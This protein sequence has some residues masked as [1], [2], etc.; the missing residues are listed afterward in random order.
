MNLQD[1]I[2]GNTYKVKTDF[3]GQMEVVVNKRENDPLYPFECTAARFGIT[4]KDVV[5]PINVSKSVNFPVCEIKNPPEP[6]KGLFA[7][8][9]VFCGGSLGAPYQEDL[10]HA[11]CL[12]ETDKNVVAPVK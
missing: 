7:G 6:K 5:G 3:T 2:P 4:A 11:E 12:S 8:Y 10:F 1:I 9:C